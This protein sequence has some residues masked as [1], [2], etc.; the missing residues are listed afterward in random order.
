[1]SDTNL[2]EAIY[3]S[4]DLFDEHDARNK[5]EFQNEIMALNSKIDNLDVRL[6]SK[7][8][9]LDAKI[10]KVETKLNAKMD[11]LNARMDVL[12]MKIDKVEEKLST[13]IEG[14]IDRFDDM[15]EHQNKW[16]TVFGILFTA[17]AIIAPVAVAVVQHYLK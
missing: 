5:A 6:N 12:D 13:A 1:M 3:V 11:V 8:D 16:F 9:S 4:K 15:K 14:L 17:A 10:D 7:I 2:T